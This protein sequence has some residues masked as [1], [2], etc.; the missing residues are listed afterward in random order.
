MPATIIKTEE[1]ISNMKACNRIL[2]F[3]EYATSSG[4]VIT[5][6]SG[7]GF[8]VDDED[9]NFPNGNEPVTL[10]VCAM[11][12]ESYTNSCWCLQYGSQHNPII[13]F[14]HNRPTLRVHNTNTVITTNYD[15]AFDTWYHLCATHDG[16]VLKFYVNGS[17]IGE[18][19][20]TLGTKKQD[21][22]LVLGLTGSSANFIIP[23][24]IAD[25]R[26]Y[27]RALSASEVAALAE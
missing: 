22:P 8:I 5:G 23:I 21:A 11:Q 3:S 24:V 16:S 6:I 15:V 10:A 4:N 18:V 25:A 20:I 9:D 17:L 27:N 7:G 1:T 2:K 13:G 12:T 26:I 19:G 14:N